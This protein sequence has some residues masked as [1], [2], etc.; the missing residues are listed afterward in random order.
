MLKALRHLGRTYLLTMLGSAGA[1]AALTVVFTHVVT[2]EVFGTW[3]TMLPMFFVLFAL[4]YGLYIPS[5]YRN[6]ALSFGC[7][8]WDFFWACQAAFVIAAL[9]FAVISLLAGGLPSILPN[10]YA[11]Y[12]LA[13]DMRASGAPVWFAP[14]PLAGLVLV[15]LALQLIGAAGGELVARHKAMGVVMLIVTMLLGIVCTVLTLFV[16]DGTIVLPPAVIWGALGCLVAVAVVCDV[17]FYRS[18]R[19]AVVR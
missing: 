7:R 15:E 13:S 1:I 16:M 12:E 11:S 19:K 10:G 2:I 17:L 14:A 3:Y 8:R 18:N 4:I 6:T 9:G 5:L